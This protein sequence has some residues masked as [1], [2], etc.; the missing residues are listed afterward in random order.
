MTKNFACRI[1]ADTE[2]LATFR[3]Q[4]GRP[5]ADIGVAT[6]LYTGPSASAQSKPRLRWTLELHA[7]FVSAVNQLGGP[8]KATPKGILKLMGV[9]GLTIYHIKSHL[10]K[11]R[12]NIRLPGEGEELSSESEGER[13]RQRER[14]RRRTQRSKR[15]RAQWGKK[16]STD[17]DSEDD[18]EEEEEAGAEPV[19]AEGE[20]QDGQVF[21]KEEGQFEPEPQMQG[22]STSGASGSVSAAAHVPGETKHDRQRN[23]EEALL[24][25]MEMQKKLHEQLEVSHPSPVAQCF[26]AMLV[27]H[28]CL[29]AY[30]QHPPKSTPML[31]LR[32]GSSAALPTQGSMGDQNTVVA[33]V[34]VAAAATADAG[35][36]RPLY[37]Q[38][39]RAR[40]SSGQ[41]CHARHSR[42]TRGTALISRRS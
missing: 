14:R 11:Y 18:E 39:H 4:S 5:D 13:R 31:K 19:V 20:V 32:N 29:A 34:A 7:R 30:H 26:K 1:A 15:G 42:C 36:A 3:M 2:K 21:V 17:D 24:K 25:Q 16:P 35:G 40:G 23:L 9:E 28:H 41:D 38:P 37:S 10:Q 27:S 33:G 6:S 8:D 22:C 12:I